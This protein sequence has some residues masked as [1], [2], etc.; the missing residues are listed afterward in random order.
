MER[1]TAFLL[2][3]LLT[4]APVFAAEMTPEET[5]MAVDHAFSAR[6]Q[7]VGAAQAFGE[8]AAPNGVL[9]RNGKRPVMG[10]EAIKAALAQ[11]P[12]AIFR[13]QPA[14]ATIAASGDMGTTS[15]R[16]TYQ[17]RRS[18]S[19]DAPI[20]AG[21]YFTVWQRQPDGSWKYTADFG[22]I[23]DPRLTN[24][25]PSTPKPDGE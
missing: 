2:L 13:W 23:L 21:H 18:A 4:V 20:Y 17:L 15:G 25:Q 6:A 16:F 1:L 11:D 19:P 14:E 9:Y 10:P 5:L 24:P 12:P 3:S 22:T 7:E 8:Y